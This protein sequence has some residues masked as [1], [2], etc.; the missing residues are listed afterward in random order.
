MDHSAATNA[1]AFGMSFA[2]FG[3]FIGLIVIFLLPLWRIVSKTG[4][5]G[6]LSL[7][8]YIPVINIVMVLILAF[9]KWPI[10]KEF[11]TLRNVQ[12]IPAQQMTP[13]EVS[14]NGVGSS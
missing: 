8:L 10:E 6:A 3:I 2:V 7:L 1:A 5:P 11:E 14:R 9:T 4:L 12:K 13:D